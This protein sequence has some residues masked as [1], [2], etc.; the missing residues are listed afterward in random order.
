MSDDKTSKH[1]TKTQRIVFRAA[2]LFGASSDEIDQAIIDQRR[3][4][5]RERVRLAIAQR[6][7]RIKLQTGRMVQ[8]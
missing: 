7:L 8:Q 4:R 3:A 1:L 5:Q 6:R 2:T